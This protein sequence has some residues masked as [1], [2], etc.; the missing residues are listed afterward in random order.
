MSQKDRDKI[1]SDIFYF[2]RARYSYISFDFT[3][4]AR[5]YL[6]VAILPLALSANLYT[7]CIENRFIR[8]PG[9]R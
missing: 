7:S 2:F 3:R 9:E 6:I 4:H 8:W 1:V 5:G